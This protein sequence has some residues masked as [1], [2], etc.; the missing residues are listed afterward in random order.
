MATQIGDASFFHDGL[1]ATVRTMFKNLGW[2]YQFAGGPRNVFTTGIQTDSVKLAIAL[3][4]DRLADCVHVYAHLVEHAASDVRGKLAEFIARA[5]YG[6]REGKF[7]LDM[8]DGEV[9]FHGRY[10]AV[11]DEE[12]CPM[13][14]AAFLVGVCNH[15]E[16]YWPGLNG[17]M[18]DRV[19]PEVAIGTIEN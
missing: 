14:L 7:E 16:K 9:R 12:P 18:V 19:A 6:L 10:V 17:V 5:N 11:A 13:Q 3:D 1:V 4:V 2:K 15:V 8:R